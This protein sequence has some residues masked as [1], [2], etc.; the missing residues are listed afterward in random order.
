MYIYIC[1]VIRTVSF[2]LNIY[3]RCILYTIEYLTH[4][5]FYSIKFICPHPC[6]N[7]KS[8]ILCQILY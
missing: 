6:L 8:E 1:T 3:L 5:D 4:T 7:I 2:V